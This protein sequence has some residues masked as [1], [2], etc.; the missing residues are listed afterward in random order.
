MHCF[1]AIYLQIKVQVLEEQLC[2]EMKKNK[3]CNVQMEQL[4]K[5][6]LQNE[7]VINRQPFYQISIYNIL[8]RCCNMFHFLFMSFLRVKY[9][10]LL[11]NFNELQSEKTAIQ[12]QFENGLSNVQTIEANM[13]V[14]ILLYYCHFYYYLYYY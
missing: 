5:D 3:E 11:S 6:I 13:K 4:R 10:E 2:T 8:L 1:S 7:W 9:E 12:E 14:W